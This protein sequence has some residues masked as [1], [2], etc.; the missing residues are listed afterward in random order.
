[1]I[2]RTN[3]RRACAL[4]LAVAGLG[5]SAPA[6]ADGNVKCGAGPQSGWKAMADLKKRAW[7]EGWE[8]LKTQVEGDCYEVYARNAQ[9]QSIEAFFHPETLEK[10]V[11]FR[12]GKEVYRAKGFKG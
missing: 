9:G 6:L 10:L 2:F 1:M 7:K 4:G 8:L 3:L 12:R 5:L 11:V